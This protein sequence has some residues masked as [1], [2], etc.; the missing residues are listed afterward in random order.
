KNENTSNDNAIEIINCSNNNNTKTK[1]NSSNNDGTEARN[2]S[3]DIAVKTKNNSSN[4]DD[5]EII[6]CFNKINSTKTGNKK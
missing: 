2:H 3:D 4:N 1:N 5:I 6:S